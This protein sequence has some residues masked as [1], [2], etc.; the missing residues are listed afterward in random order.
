MASLA[1]QLC[2]GLLALPL[3]AFAAPTEIVSRAS[4][5]M[6]TDWLVL[7]HLD[8]GFDA[9]AGQL[10]Y[11]LVIRSSWDSEVDTIFDSG[12]RVSGYGIPVAVTLTIGDK[13]F[14]YATAPW[15]GDAGYLQ[16][17]QYGYLH[18]VD[19]S[20]GG[21]DVSVSL[22]HA[23]PGGLT[24]SPLA[25]RDAGAGGGVPG[26]LR[27]QTYPGNPDAPGSWQ[28]DANAIASSVQVTSPVPEPGMGAM[29]L[30]GLGALL[31]RRRREPARA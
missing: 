28:M 26:Y 7:E 3:A 15:Q 27:I 18:E 12:Q 24:E 30:A 9:S 11:E 2:A 5:M 23:F 31:W 14:E 25:P 4:G 21:Y 16:T 22:S 17:G 8:F 10:P 1:R 13:T 19:F 20:Y 29:A 6:D